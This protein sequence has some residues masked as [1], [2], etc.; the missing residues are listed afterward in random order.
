M[1]FN[2]LD[3]VV[4]AL[5]AL[6]A[7]GGWRLGLITRAVSW[8]GTIIGVLIAAR[9]LPWAVETAGESM[10]RGQL[11]LIAVGLLLGGAVFGQALGLLLG[12]RLRMSHTSTVGHRID[13][14]GGAVA[15]VLG[16]LAA[17]W[18]LVPAIADVPGWQ[19]RQARTS[20]IVRAVDDVLPPAPDATETL[21]RLLGEQYPRV[22]DGLRPT[23]GVGPPPAGSGLGR[24][25]ADRVAR[26]TVMIISEACDRVQEGSGFVVRTG[27]VVTNAHVVAGADSSLVERSDGSRV[28]GRVVAF[29]PDRDLALLS[30]PGI[31]RPPLRVGDARSG[32]RGAVFGHPGGGPL[33]L[34]PFQVGER[35]EALGNDIYGEDRT[36]RDVL[37]LAADLAPGDSG[38]AL[39]DPQ[40][41]VV[42]VAFAVAPDRPGVAYALSTTELRTVLS[43]AGRA[44]VSTGSC[45]T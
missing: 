39:V 22:F 32:T 18:L 34:S 14:V 44:V 25:A 9:I 36:R 7:V 41:R 37:I 17:V 3:G 20:R 6:G 38:S 31:D 8:V 19:S 33:K 12:S 40:G 30:V 27:L 10:G 45:L 1:P 35:V 4:V 13:A 26:S 16:V 23:P 5:A 43:G 42:G 15:G 2:A 29:D 11:L 28:P 21:R 24:A